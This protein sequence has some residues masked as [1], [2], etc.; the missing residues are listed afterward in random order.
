LRL[1]LNGESEE[2]AELMNKISEQ[3]KALDDTIK[4]LNELK[5]SIKSGSAQADGANAP[6]MQ[7]MPYPYPG[8]PYPPYPYP[9]YPGYPPY[10]YPPQQT[11]VDESQ[12]NS[13]PVQAVDQNKANEP[14]PIYDNTSDLGK[15][16]EEI[17]ADIEAEE[18]RSGKTTVR[19]LSFVLLFLALACIVIPFL[20]PIIGFTF[21][22]GEVVIKGI[23]L[24]DA[25][26][27]VLTGGEKYLMSSN[28]LADFVV[29]SLALDYT[30]MHVAIW[31]FLGSFFLLMLSLLF[32]VLLGFIRVATGNT[33][34]RFYFSSLFS[35][36]V[37]TVNAFSA[38]IVARGTDIS[39]IVEF[40]TGY[41]RLGYYALFGILVARMFIALF[42]KRTRISRR[43]R[44]QEAIRQARMEAYKNVK[45]SVKK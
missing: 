16:N 18:R 38:F 24:A 37:L 9:P 3:Q 5:E 13:N 25:T 15:T 40:V 29:E 22:E 6:F 39:L 10:P 4:E 33:K 27:F 28:W 7:G 42:V 43:E 45:A 12:A 35:L 2:K 44:R 26:V 31:T 23:H 41:M 19:A 8:Y 11:N 1:A 17:M 21:P 14:A 34:G 20:L 32:E 36:F 30:T